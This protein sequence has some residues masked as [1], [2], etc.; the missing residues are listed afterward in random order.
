M[1]F[2]GYGKEG[3][4]WSVKEGE[5]YDAVLPY[6]SSERAHFRPRRNVSPP[7]VRRMQYRGSLM[8]RQ[9]SNG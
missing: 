7:M 1:K 4:G 5:G 3:R 2:L 6:G 8:G 9:S